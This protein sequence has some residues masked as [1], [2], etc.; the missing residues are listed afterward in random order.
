MVYTQHGTHYLP[1][2]VYIQP[3]TPTLPTMVYIQPG[4]PTTLYHPGYTPGYTPPPSG[5]RSTDEVLLLAEEE[6][7][8]SNP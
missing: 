4:I 8:G 3:G 5:L 6:V 7:L 2:M 1:T